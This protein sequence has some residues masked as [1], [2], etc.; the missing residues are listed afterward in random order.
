MTSFLTY[1]GWYNLLGPVL[2][3]ALQSERIAD[4]VLRRGTEILAQ[5][6]A[7]GPYG[8]LWLWWTAGANGALGFVMVRAVGWPRDAQNDVVVAALFVYLEDP[9]S[10]AR[11][12]RALH[13]LAPERR[14][15]ILAAI[16]KLDL[17]SRRAKTFFA[18]LTS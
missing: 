3:F 13:L 11:Y 16:R 17:T 12:R 9:L 18:W 10:L 2:L 5:P 8:R 7:H 14:D 1:V 4:L 6:Y 15:A